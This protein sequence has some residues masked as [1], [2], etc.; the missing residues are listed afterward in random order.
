MAANGN[1]QNY[2]CRPVVVNRA[3]RPRTRAGSIQP[4]GTNSGSTITYPARPVLITL[5]FRWRVGTHP[6]DTALDWEGWPFPS[7]NV[8]P[9]K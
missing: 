7:L 1:L 9:T 6:C 5:I 8:P 4:A 3:E 2:A